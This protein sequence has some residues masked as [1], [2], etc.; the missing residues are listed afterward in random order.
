[1]RFESISFQ[2]LSKPQLDFNGKE[3]K[4]ERYINRLF[5]ENKVG[6]T[7]E[8]ANKAYDINEHQKGAFSEYNADQYFQKVFDDKPLEGHS[9]FRTMTER[10]R[11]NIQEK[12]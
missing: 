2:E 9:D 1:M 7:N 5:D 8:I 10:E 3:Q 6:S 12:T 4:A 11:E